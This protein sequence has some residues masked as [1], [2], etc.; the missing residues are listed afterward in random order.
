MPT[1][2]PASA[3]VGGKIRSS[4]DAPCRA[5]A[6]QLTPIRLHCNRLFSTCG[7]RSPATSLSPF[8]RGGRNCRWASKGWSAHCRGATACEPGSAGAS[9]EI[10]N[11]IDVTAT[12]DF[13]RHFDVLLGYSHL[14]SGD[15]IEESGAAD[16]INFTYLMFQYT[17]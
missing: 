4:T 12:Y 10:G 2:I 17:F 9:R 6:G 8:V 15:F 5:A 11:E 14:Y 13:N 16:D 7:F 1:T 3:T